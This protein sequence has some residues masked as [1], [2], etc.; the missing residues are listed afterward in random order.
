MQQIF[1]NVNLFLAS[2]TR[3]AILFFR[4]VCS[5]S[6]DRQN[7]QFNEKRGGSTSNRTR[8]PNRYCW[9][10]S[11]QNQQ[12]NENQRSYGRCNKPESFISRAQK[13]FIPNDTI[14]NHNELTHNAHTHTPT[15]KHV[16]MYAY[17]KKRA[18]TNSA[19]IHRK[20]QTHVRIQK[21]TSR[22]HMPHTSADASAK[23]FH[24]QRGYLSDYLWAALI[25][26]L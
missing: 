22:T 9:K 10:Y 15:H 5:P 4:S 19:H 13:Y 3:T 26:S 25:R 24:A 8:N 1:R 20:H 12:Q 17:I 16:D 21:A 6:M 2:A 11:Y 18:H 14:G 23:R 7:A